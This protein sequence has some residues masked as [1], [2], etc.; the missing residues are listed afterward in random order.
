MTDERKD[1][2]PEWLPGL[3]DFVAKNA[4]APEAE[5]RKLCAIVGEDYG[6]EAK[7]MAEALFAE[8]R[9]VRL[10]KAEPQTRIDRRGLG[11]GVAGPAAPK[12]PVSP[13]VAAVLARK[14]EAAEAAEARA[15]EDAKALA[16]AKAAMRGVPV[17]RATAKPPVVV[18]EPEAEAKVIA[19][20]AKTQALLNAVPGGVQGNAVVLGAVAVKPKAVPKAG[21]APGTVGALAD[22]Y[23]RTA[24]YPSEKFAVATA[25]SIVGTLIGRRIAGPSD[26][27]GVT[28][29]TYQALIGETGWGKEQVRVVNKRAFAAARAD[30]LIGPGRFKSA[31]AMVKYLTTHKQFCSVQDELAAILSAIAD[32]KSNVSARSTKC[33]AI[34]GALAGADTTARPACQTTAS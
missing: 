30:A 15:R 18:A 4:D 33:S 23:M 27:R 31:Q 34:C 16:A 29:S 5:Q 28:T 22:Y 2:A 21:L 7:A 10:P 1:V 9:A 11:C 17:R 24:M 8:A 12:P 3:K 19:F 26:A 14:A 32:P 20:D 25:H 6:A 13:V